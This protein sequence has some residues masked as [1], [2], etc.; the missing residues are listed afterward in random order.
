[1][2]RL[3]GRELDKPADDDDDEERESHWAPWRS[4]WTAASG[5]VRRPAPGFPVRIALMIY[6]TSSVGCCTGHLDLDLAR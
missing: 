1:M 4:R 6:I 2:F 3:L 5:Y